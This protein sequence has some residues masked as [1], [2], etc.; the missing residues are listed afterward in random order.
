MPDTWCLIFS[1]GTGQRG[2]RNDDTVKNTNV[3]QMFA[4][5]EDKPYLETFYDPGLGAPAEGS[6][7]W[8]R[9]FR[10]L[11]SKATGW[12]ITANIT[13]CYEALL[14]K[15]KPGMKIGLFGFSRGAYTARCLGG[16]LSTCGI[17]TMDGG[18]PISRDAKGPGAERRRAIAD[19]AVATY[20]IT[21]E[22]ERKAAGASFAVRFVS[23]EKV[24]D[25]IG[26]FDTVKSL[27]LPGLMNLVNPWKHEFHDN[28]L[29]VRVPVGLQALAVDENR[30]AFLPELWADVDAEGQAAG[31]VIEQVWFPG[32]HSDIG[33]GYDDDWKLADLA[34][35]WMLDRLRN[36]A[37]LHI[38]LTVA[39]AD[40]LCGRGH[41]ERTGMGVMWL[42]AARVI[43]SEMVDR[44]MLCG[45]IE[46]RFDR[47]QPLYRPPS[48][49]SHPRVR[50]YYA[51]S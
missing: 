15:W 32:V 40:N 5:A 25:V 41:D 7:D 22:G 35:D 18:A 34:L 24:P 21:A 9:T 29:S 11:W 46:E 47:Y 2:V 50:R 39:M 8:A 37:R 23:A 13:D 27:G 51:L 1:D 44:D 3:F 12:G 4:A 48:L 38:P 19:R 42:P 49:A 16:V 6:N 43:R 28:E 36:V 14:M 30:E 10:N 31:Q 45:R 33:G 20:K 26:V 17:A